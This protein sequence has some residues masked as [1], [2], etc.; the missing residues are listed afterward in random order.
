MVFASSFSLQY[1]P[2]LEVQK[3]TRNSARKH[4]HKAK[5]GLLSID[6]GRCEHLLLP[7]APCR[8]TVTRVLLG[9]NTPQSRHLPDYC[10]RAWW[11]QN[12]VTQQSQ[13]SDGTRH[14]ARYKYTTKPSQHK[15][16]RPLLYR[17]Y[18][19]PC[20]CALSHHK[21]F[22]QM[23]VNVVELLSESWVN[24]VIF[25]R[26]I[27]I[28]R[29]SPC[30]ATNVGY[31][32][33]E[34]P[35]TKYQATKLHLSHFWTYIPCGKRVEVGYALGYVYPRANNAQPIYHGSLPRHQAGTA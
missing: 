28:Y 9:P 17:R 19:S 3:Q 5:S 13:Y 7:R 10:I 4:T 25:K 27:F 11:W 22:Y 18:T 21:I 34:S 1:T 16:E 8:E 30:S 2:L 23:G 33:Q 20:L 31:Y 6:H 29:L 35:H 32:M 12:Q 26:F 14:I 15:N 24:N